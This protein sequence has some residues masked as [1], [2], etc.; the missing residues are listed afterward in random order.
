MKD[1]FKYPVA[2][3]N[4]YYIDDTYYGDATEGFL[5]RVNEY[6]AGQYIGGL[7]ILGADT[8]AKSANIQEFIGKYYE[9]VEDKGVNFL[10]RFGWSV[11]NWIEGEWAPMSVI[12]TAAAFTRPN[13]TVSDT[14]V[15]RVTLGTQITGTKW[16]SNHYHFFGDGDTIGAVIDIT[17]GI[18]DTGVTRYAR[19]TAAQTVDISST[20]GSYTLPFTFDT[21]SGLA[22]VWYRQGNGVY[23][24]PELPTDFETGDKVR[25]DQNFTEAHDTGTANQTG[26]DFYLEKLGVATYEVYTDAAR[27]TKATL[28]ENYHGTVDVTFTGTTAT[29]TVDLTALDLNHA[30]AGFKTQLQGEN[31]GWMRLTYV[32][33]TGTVTESDD[34]TIPVTTS[35][36]YNN[37]FHYQHT[38]SNVV[39]IFDQRGSST[40]ADFIVNCIPTGFTSIS[41]ADASRTAGTYTNVSVTGGS[42]SSLTVDVTVDGTGAVTSLTV[43]TAGSGY[44]DGE[45]ITIADSDLGGGGA[46]DVTANVTVFGSMTLTIHLINPARN[47]GGYELINRTLAFG[48]SPELRGAVD[49]SG[50][51]H[52]YMSDAKLVQRGNRD[53]IYLQD[54]GTGETE[55]TAGAKLAFNYYAAGA[56]SGTN[57]LT[58]SFTTT[59]SKAPTVNITVDS[60]ND[61]G[62]LDDFTITNGGIRSRT[63]A[64][65][66]DGLKSAIYFVDAA[67]DFVPTRSALYL[68]ERAHDTDSEWDGSVD[69][70]ISRT[71]PQHV[72]PVSAELIVNQPSVVA[73]SQNAK[74]FV[75]KSDIVRYQIKLEYGFMSYD[76]FRIFQARLEAAQGQFVPFY[77]NLRY[78]DG[79]KLLFHT[80][81]RR[82]Y[83]GTEVVPRHGLNP[84]DVATGATPAAGAT[85]LYLDG[86]PNN[87]DFLTL[88]EHF[89][90]NSDNGGLHIAN[91]TSTANIFGE[92]RVRLT[93][94]VGPTAFHQRAFPN[95]THVIVSLAE[96]SVTINK[97]VHGF[98]SFSCTFDC[99]EFK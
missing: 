52:Y 69:F 36:D 55:Q 13:G 77:I 54:D 32:A 79:T 85:V 56:S 73:T 38:G 11:P 10:S 83:N 86:I 46:A 91:N 63:E 76:D 44:N 92:A 47:S 21:Q 39:D 24:R 31:P 65:Q 93:R 70:D 99:D 25:L 64:L 45:Q 42:G 62:K 71:W 14:L 75:R 57:W 97:E 58:D 49:G 1:L 4:G 61:G 2:G 53:F 48:V 35:I 98:Y 43:N 50:L 82:L 12:P 89:G 84:D 33:N 7:E 20:S 51:P 72:K 23:W 29:H 3:T 60:V 68:E 66:T 80:D 22:A 6:A 81:D 27:T 67:S 37:T 18:Q 87:Y 95:L 40:N 19:N 17:D 88:G 9:Y 34:S 96:D 90:F 59:Q 41:G 8:A 26:T 74:K 94:P 5:K 16:G 15:Y 28:T 30:S 78:P